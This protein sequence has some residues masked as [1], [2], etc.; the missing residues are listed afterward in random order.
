MARPRKKATGLGDTVEQVLQATGIDKVAKFVL[1]EDC[2][3]DERKKKLNAMFPYRNTNCLTEEEYQWL[4][5]TQVL[6]QNTFKPSEQTRIIQI[7]NRVFN[8]RQE[9][10]SCASCFRDIVVKL[11]KVLDEY[12]A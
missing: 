1:G 4:N 2:N 6:K 11:S 5:E 9:P 3:C 8:L 12:E 7:Y 10:T